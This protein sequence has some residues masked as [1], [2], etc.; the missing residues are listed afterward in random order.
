MPRAARRFRCLHNWLKNP[1]MMNRRQPAAIS[2]SATTIWLRS[3]GIKTRT[4]TTNQGDGRILLLVRL[5]HS[6]FI[7]FNGFYSQKIA[8]RF[9]MRCMSRQLYCQSESM[10]FFNRQS[11]LFALRR[12][13]LGRLF[14]AFTVSECRL[15]C[16]GLFFDTACGLRVS[17]SVG[18][19]VRKSTHVA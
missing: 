18:H 14:H 6:P 15:P 12:V 2:H 1:K 13:T 8:S 10:P 3:W 17:G 11:S 9:G 19:A 16:G 7:L 5:L 4:T